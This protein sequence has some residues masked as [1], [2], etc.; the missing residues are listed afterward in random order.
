MTINDYNRV[1]EKIDS[2]TQSLK[3]ALSHNDDTQ[4]DRLAPQLEKELIE[5]NVY[6]TIFDEQ[7]ISSAVST[8]ERY[9]G[10]ETE[11]NL[12]RIRSHLAVVHSVHYKLHAITD[13]DISI[14]TLLYEVLNEWPQLNNPIECVFEQ[15]IEEELGKIRSQGPRVET[16]QA[17]FEKYFL[18]LHK[19]GYTDAVDLIQ[20]AVDAAIA[21]F[22]R[23]SSW[24]L[25]GL[26]VI[27]G[28]GEVCGIN[29]KAN[30]R[31]PTQPL[32]HFNHEK[33][34]D[35]QNAAE[36]ARSCAAD[37]NRAIDEY[38]YEVEISRRDTSYGGNSIG[39]PLGIGYLAEVENFPISPY[40]AFTGHLEFKTRQVASVQ[41]INEKLLAAKQA[42]VFEVFL[43]EQDMPLITPDIK[44][45]KITPVNTLEQAW[46]DLKNRVYDKAEPS[47]EARIRKL[48]L[49]LKKYGV[50]LINRE[51]FPGRI[52]L[53]FYNGET[54]PVDVYHTHTVNVGGSPKSNLRQLVQRIVNEAFGHADTEQSIGK[55]YTN[56][57]RNWPVEVPT[58]E[59]RYRVKEY[60]LSVNGASEG[61][62][63][64][65]DYT[66]RIVQGQYKLQVKQYNSGKLLLQGKDDPLFAE[67]QE[68]IESIL[69]IV[70][71][72][73]DN[74]SAENPPPTRL[75]QQQAA[76][77]AVDV[78]EEWVGTDES[79]K[80]DYFG[81]LVSAAVYVNRQ[82]A[83][84][85]EEIG[86]ADSK[87]LSDKRINALAPQVE[88]ICGSRCTHVIVNPEKYNQ[89]YEQFRKEGKNLNSL[90]AWTH[91]RAL[92]N[93]LPG[94]KPRSPL[95]VLIDKFADEKYIQ[96]RFKKERLLPNVPQ[97]ELRLVQ[98]PKA[99]VNIAVAA[100]SI[101]ARF[102][103]LQQL[104]KL[105][106]DYGVELPKGSSDPN[107][108]VL[109][110]KIVA[111]FGRDE[112]SKVAKIHFST[113]GRILE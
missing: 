10:E 17:F 100:A 90:L 91:T 53:N 84:K 105:S 61:T 97:V 88:K 71:L 59:L 51:P 52:R 20:T 7:L 108:V 70:K 107:I 89:L 109:G 98:L 104:G 22:K 46:N 67:V 43:S 72:G 26:F 39:L 23:L 31:K 94:F 29:I 113:T 102:Y 73:V 80:G 77:K 18:Y 54:I 69:G 38:T 30:P 19:N 21:S 4:A 5:E 14:E 66:A 63:N 12:T 8:L 45:I 40:I 106:A 76:V 47:L 101:L 16:L 33:D 36:R 1:I 81:P 78:G 85:L 9:F 13:P 35:L 11:D 96:D 103:F 79:G 49:L 74:T 68:K 65:C 60:L 32:V 15:N 83:N 25:R 42:G 41:G 75:S 3:A 95:T 50:R 6:L 44:G 87:S 110:K 58:P 86:V 2:L 82:I 28:L 111:K 99:E 93:I 27:Q 92:E 24:T 37:L 62:E 112:L 57:S 55:T 56:Q 64:H 48:E 34:Q